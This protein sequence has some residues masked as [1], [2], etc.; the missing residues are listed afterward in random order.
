MEAL[1]REY[2]PNT[3]V[4]IWGICL[5]CG[6]KHTGKCPTI[7]DAVAYDVEEV[8]LLTEGKANSGRE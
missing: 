3:I 5:K 6:T 7:I 8:K 2:V 4:N 1:K